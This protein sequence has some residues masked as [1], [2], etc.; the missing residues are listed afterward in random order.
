M[1]ITT[2][3]TLIAGGFV[4][5]AALITTTAIFLTKGPTHNVEVKGTDN[6]TSTGQNG[7]ITGK[8]ISE[9][10]K[11]GITAEKVTINVGSGT[12]A[13]PTLVA[14]NATI[15]K[16]ADRYT[17][18]IPFQ[19]STNTP[20]GQVQFAAQIEGDTDATILSFSPGAGVSFNIR[21]FLSTDRRHASLSFS[22]AEAANPVIL[23]VSA[24]CKVTI[25]GSHNLKP[26]TLDIK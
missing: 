13:T 2:K 17:T 4:L 18:H 9:G 16:E 23:R 24:T 11:G 15:E 21:K 22:R 12:P 14:Q 20:L 7:G 6:V 26:F 19:S 1:R 25:S 8:V 3:N 10:Q 5:V